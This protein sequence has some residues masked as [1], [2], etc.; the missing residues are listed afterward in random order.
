LETHF[1]EIRD[2]VVKIKD[3]EQLSFSKKK[4]IE[5]GEIFNKIAQKFDLVDIYI[6]DATVARGKQRKEFKRIFKIMFN[7]MAETPSYIRKDTKEKVN[8]FLKFK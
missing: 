7:M 5:K 8:R 3:L 1:D 6:S 4:E 2:G